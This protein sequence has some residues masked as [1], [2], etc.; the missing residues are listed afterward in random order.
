VEKAFEAL[1]PKAPVA[2]VAPEKGALHFMP[3]PSLFNAM[4]HPLIPYA[5]RGVAWYQGE[6]NVGNALYGKHLQILVRDWRRW[7]KQGD[8]P[9]YVNQLAG[10]GA[11]KLEPTESPWAECR[12]MQMAVLKLPNTGIANLIDTCEDG[13]LHPLNKQDAGRRLAWVALAKTYEKR[14]LPS[15]GPLF[16]S[17]RRVGSKVSVQF[18]KN[19]S[20]LAT[21]SLPQNFR[22]NLRKPEIP[23]VPLELPS[24]GSPL[25]GFALCEEVRQADGTTQLVWRNA[26][27]RIEGESV[28][29]WSDL[30]KEPVGVRYA[31]ADHP[32]CNLTSAAG[33][34]AFPFRFQWKASPAPK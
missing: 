27:A 21:K 13:D 5:I 8:F 31:W 34:P 3:V 16:E 24:P 32:V 22:P 19:G 12:E 23:P 7:W 28:L 4:V 2:P 11:R 20:G 30:I 6:S 9:F 25:Q 1:P 14:D 17:A 10:F 18:Q 33:L 26:L 29:V 15:S